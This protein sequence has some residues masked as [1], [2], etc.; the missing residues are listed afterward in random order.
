MY[1]VMPK[2]SSVRF[3]FETSFSRIVFGIDEIGK[4]VE[5][6]P[7]IEVDGMNEDIASIDERMVS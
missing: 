2:F 7:N 4:L 5:D 1:V 3:W 6:H